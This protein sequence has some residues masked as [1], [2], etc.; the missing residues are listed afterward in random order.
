MEKNNEMVY[1]EATDRLKELHKNY[2]GNKSGNPDDAHW[3]DN[4]DSINDTGC[5]YAQDWVAADKSY[6]REGY[7]HLTEQEFIEFMGLDTGKNHATPVVYDSVDHPSHY[8]QG[9][10]ECLDAIRESMTSESYNGFLKGQVQKYMWRYEKKSNPLEDLRKAEFYLKR[11]I[12]EYDNT[13]I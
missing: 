12:K 1:T 10:I 11:L 6:I 9:S 3:F 2:T 8:T 7:K 13:G 4:V 5:F